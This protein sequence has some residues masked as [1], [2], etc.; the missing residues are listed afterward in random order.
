[1]VPVHRAC[2]LGVGCDVKQV[3]IGTLMIDGKTEMREAGAIRR[4]RKLPDF[5]G[6]AFQ[7]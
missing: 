4:P 7:A 1:M 3:A 2:G 6:L 5:F